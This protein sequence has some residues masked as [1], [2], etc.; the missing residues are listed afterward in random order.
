MS[1][2]WCAVCGTAHSPSRGC[3]GD[4]RATGPERHG[5][6][7]VVETPHGIEAYGVLVA[8]ARDRW[9]ARILTYPNILW[10]T[11]GGAGTMKFV[12]ATP[13][14]AEAGAIAFVERHVRARGYLR[15]DA[16]DPVASGRIRAEARPGAILGGPAARK[17]HALPVQFGI[18]PA[19]FAAMTANV[20]EN[21]M[22]VTT[23]APLDAGLALR[24]SMDLDVGAL[25]MKGQVVWRR[26]R[27]VLGRPVGMGIRL[28]APPERYVEFIRQL[29]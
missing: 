25:A 6:R 3:P 12:G 15:R 28:V 2:H 18:G 11:P 23:L 14:D 8:P 27:M 10:T 1:V 19:L 24:V 5:W 17:N 7:V 4:L 16:L 21:G 9:R 22:F 29:R 13:Q 26:K 20:S